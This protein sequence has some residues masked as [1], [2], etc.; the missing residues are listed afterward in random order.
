ML[1]KTNLNLIFSDP[2]RGNTKIKIETEHCANIFSAKFLPHS[3]NSK[4]VSCS[5]DGIIIYTG[6]LFNSCVFFL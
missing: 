4:I 6:F 5:G 2:W 1:F 3:C